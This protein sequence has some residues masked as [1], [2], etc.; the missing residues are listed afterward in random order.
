MSSREDYDVVIVGGGPA[1]LSAALMLGRARRRVLLTDAGSPRNARAHEVH[2]FVTRDG[3]PPREFR[4][5]GREQ[6]ATYPNVELRELLVA[7]VSGSAGEFR[8]EFG[9]GQSVRTRR[10]LLCLG[11]IDEPLEIP[12]YRELWGKSVFQCPYCHG[13]EVRDGAFAYLAPSAALVEHAVFLR[14]WSPDLVVFTDARFEVPEEARA[15]LATAGVRIEERS[16]ASLEASADGEKLA[17]IVLQG[18][19]RVAREVLFSAPPQRQTPLVKALE[20][21][22]DELGCVRV[23]ERHESSRPGVFAAGDL[24]TRMQSALL[25]AAAGATAAHWLNYGLVMEPG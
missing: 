21:S 20:L 17:A 1:G 16:I 10:V 9:A 22:L 5:I 4:R 23:N 24:T 7:A 25:G 15:R 3:T 2:G 12:G 19:E 8:V 18:G 6:L 11:V 14:N 13:W